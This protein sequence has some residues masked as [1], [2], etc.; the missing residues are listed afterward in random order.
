MSMICGTM[1]LLHEAVAASLGKRDSDSRL[2]PRY[3]LIASRSVPGV[4]YFA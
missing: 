1:K 2:H 4:Q 3:H